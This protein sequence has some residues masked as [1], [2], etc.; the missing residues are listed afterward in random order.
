MLRIAWGAISFL[1][2]CSF[3][4][5]CQKLGPLGDSG[6]QALKHG[7]EERA[8]SLIEEALAK[9]SPDHPLLYESLGLAY[10]GRSAVD[11]AENVKR[12]EEAM[13]KAISL[14]GRAAIV[15]DRSLEKGFLFMKNVNIM[16]VKRG[17]LYITKEE[18]RFEA[19]DNSESLI[20]KP[21]EIEDFNVKSG[22]GSSTGF[23]HLDLKKGGYDFRTAN[24]NTEEA[25]LIFRLIE[26][27][28]GVL[29]KERRKKK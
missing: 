26:R 16:K 23:F 10:L 29:P 27:H 19:S 5:K 11:A 15:V 9:E 8:V 24:F 3:L 2:V 20:F 1:F 13:D 7:S 4:G 21:L 22:A 14:G 12:A 6:L 25:N 17:R 28:M 18:L